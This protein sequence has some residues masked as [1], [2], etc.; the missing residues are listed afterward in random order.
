MP[1]L[2]RSVVEVGT[3]VVGA[4]VIVVLAGG[5]V[6]GTTV[7][8][9]TVVG[10]LAL[11][12]VVVD[13]AVVLTSVVDGA[14]ALIVVGETMSAR[15]SWLLGGSTWLVDSVALHPASTVDTITTSNERLSVAF[16]R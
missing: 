13:A 12:I 2:E 4:V 3:D 5:F 10:A 6:V 15:T 16:R 1:V 8:G 14:C 9:M 11:G 7:L